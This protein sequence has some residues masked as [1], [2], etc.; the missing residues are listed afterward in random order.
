M[1]STVATMQGISFGFEFDNDFGNCYCVQSSIRYGCE[2]IT[3][4]FSTVD[5]FLFLI[6]LP[7]LGKHHV[8]ILA[9]IIAGLMLIFFVLGTISAEKNVA[10]IRIKCLQS[11]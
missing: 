9:V 6:F 4:T 5:I 7:H 10:F 11:K 2:Y 8:E 1:S 3:I